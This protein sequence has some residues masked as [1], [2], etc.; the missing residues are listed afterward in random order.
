MSSPRICLQ[1]DPYI[2]LFLGKTSLDRTA[3]VFRF[4]KLQY[5]D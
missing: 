2:K 4:E 1:S 3:A 5:I